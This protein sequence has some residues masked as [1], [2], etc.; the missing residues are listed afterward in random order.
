[1]V[2]DESNCEFGRDAMMHASFFYYQLLEE[3]SFSCGQTSYWLFDSATYWDLLDF[4]VIEPKGV[5]LGIDDAFI[6]EAALVYILCMLVNQYAESEPQDYPNA[7]D[8]LLKAI[9]EKG[10]ALI[11][12]ISQII[13]SVRNTDLDG[14]NRTM[15]VIFN[16]YVKGR[17]AKLMEQR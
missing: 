7:D 6:R 5:S 10:L 15:V 11:P 9:K 1:V 12:E 3:G 2:V 17:F 14:F 4:K 13:E 16:S 8:H